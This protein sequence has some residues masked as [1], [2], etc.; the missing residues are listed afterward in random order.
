MNIQDIINSNVADM[1]EDDVFEALQVLNELYANDPEISDT[2]NLS[3]DLYDVLYKHAQQLNPVHA[4]FSNVGSTIRTGKIPLPCTMGSLNQLFSDEDLS[5]WK[6]QMQV[7]D[8]DEFIITAKEDG[9]ASLLSMM[10]SKLIQSFSRG[11]GYQGADTT[12]HMLQ[13]LKKYQISTFNGNVRGEVICPI[14]NFDSIKDCKKDGSSYKNPRNMVA[15]LMNKE[16]NPE[17]VL[18]ALHFVAFD[19]VNWNSSKSSMLE[20][21]K[22]SGFTV[23]E[24]KLIK[25]SDLKSDTLYEILR[26]FR[27]NT[28]YELDGVVVDINTPSKRI[29]DSSV[30]NP[31]YSFKFKENANARRVCVTGVEWNISK[32][33]YLKPTVVYEPIDILGVTCQRATGFNAAFIVDNMIGPGSIVEILRAGD[34]IPVIYRVLSPMPIRSDYEQKYELWF[35]STIKEFGEYHWT[36]NNAGKHVDIVVNTPTDEMKIQQLV[37]FATTL[38]VSNLGEGSVRNAYDQGFTSI[39]DLCEMNETHWTYAVGSNGTKIFNSLQS[40]I[41]NVDSWTFAAATGFLGRGVGRTKLKSICLARKKHV[42]ELTSLDLLNIDG[43]SDKTIDKMVDGL[44]DL[45]DIIK[46]LESYVTFKPIEKNKGKYSGLVIVFTG[47][48]DNDLEMYIL[49]H[50]G[51]VKSTVTKDVNIVIAADINDK[52][53]KLK[54]ARDLQHAGKSIQIITIKEFKEKYVTQSIIE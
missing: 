14:N 15:G 46:Q 9:N 50:D 28:P 19:I 13:V 4:F 43:I 42:H 54:K 2:Y 48:R 10:N 49:K 6:A 22:T 52:S 37:H 47:F 24:Y 30:L 38:G 44:P 16:S 27:E 7:L 33:G 1:S 5:S 12:R 11:D 39:V 21:L 26:E 17:Y 34:V 40:C 53:S 23:P 35:L 36:V 51:D 31:S 8:D 18:E 32:D 25:A 20:K 41:N 29:V 3:D 45:K